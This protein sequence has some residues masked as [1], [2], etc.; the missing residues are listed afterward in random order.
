MSVA[1]TF[2]ACMEAGTKRKYVEH[3]KLVLKE[4]FPRQTGWNNI[5]VGTVAC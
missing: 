4:K 1:G 3:L 5:V 2:V